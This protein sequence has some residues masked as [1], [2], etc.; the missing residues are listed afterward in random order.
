MLFF[1]CCFG[2]RAAAPDGAVA[3]TADSLAFPAFAIKL[4]AVFP[5]AK[6]QAILSKLPPKCN[7]F[8]FD[9]GDMSGDTLRDLVLSLKPVD[10]ARRELAVYFFI[11]DGDSMLLAQVLSRTYIAEPIEVGFSIDDGVCHVTEKRGEF[12]WE[13]AG[14]AVDGGVFKQVEFWETQ[15]LRAGS[16]LSGTGFEVQ[17]RHRTHRCSETFYRASDAKILLR[18]HSYALPVFP[19]RMKLPPDVNAAIGDT[20]YRFLQSGASSWSGPDDCSF[21]VSATY[22]S[23]VVTVV[24]RVRDDRLLSGSSPEESDRAEFHFDLSGKPKVDPGGKLRGGSEETLLGISILVGDGGKN[25]PV[26]FLS[27]G[28]GSPENLHLLR[29]VRNHFEKNDA[30]EFALSVSLPLKLFPGAP[31]RPFFGFTARYLDIDQPEHP[32]WITVASTSDDFDSV[33]PSTYGRMEF[34]PGDRILYERE[35]LHARELVAKMVAAGFM[36]GN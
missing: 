20:S 31:Q 18:H 21:A 29:Q 14:Y 9:T 2:L 27:G 25:V 32:E 6:V 28:G 15:R 3:R 26:Q 10:A 11:D 23:S 4:R 35:D 36:V 17:A 19:A 8:G 1:V 13:I 5:D 7:I 22:D 33:R 30:G 34:Y 16:G 12:H 24:M